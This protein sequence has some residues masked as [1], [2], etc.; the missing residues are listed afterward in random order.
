MKFKIPD[1]PCHLRRSGNRHQWS[2]EA[3]S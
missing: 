3:S 2:T 1:R